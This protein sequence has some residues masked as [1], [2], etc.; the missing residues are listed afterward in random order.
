MK[1]INVQDFTCS[2]LVKLPFAWDRNLCFII[3]SN[4]YILKKALLN[5]LKKTI[6]SN[7]LPKLFMLPL[8]AFLILFLYL[9]HILLRRLVVLTIHRL[10]SHIIQLDMQI[11]RS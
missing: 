1:H 8:S 2:H 10:L 11:R 4:Q 9:F 5:T 3:Q 7:F 6:L